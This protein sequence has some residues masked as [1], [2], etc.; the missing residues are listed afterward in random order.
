MHYLTELH[1][2]TF[3]VSDCGTVTSD[4]IADKYADAG[5]SSLTV[6]NH[7]SRFTFNGK[8]QKYSGGDSWEEKIEFFMNGVEVMK[9][10]SKG[11]FN[12]L[13][14]IELRLNTD[15]NDYLVYGVTKD[16]L[17]SHPELLDLKAKDASELLHKNGLLLFQAHPFRNSMK[18]TN[19]A[20]LDGIEGYN[21]HPGQDSR[22]DIAI[23][24]AKRFGLKLLSGTDFHHDH[25]T[26]TGGIITS[27]PIT[28][29]EE[30]LQT[31]KDGTYTLLNC[32]LTPIN[33]KK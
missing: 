6:T 16:F 26:P 14:G 13:W 7:L 32:G 18:M 33:S 10:A 30:L 20:L 22:N 2:H 1:C 11:R 24:W 8:N 31:L 27:Y 23:I 3:E 12:V 19:P 9:Q 29:N 17:L 5:Y 15:E 21:G 28:T 25:H 4:K